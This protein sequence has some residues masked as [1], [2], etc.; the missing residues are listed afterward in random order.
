MTLPKNNNNIFH[1]P[2]T[3][4]TIPTYTFTQGRFQSKIVEQFWTLN[5]IDFFNNEY[6]DISVSKDYLQQMI[7]KYCHG[8]LYELTKSNFDKIIKK[9][10]DIEIFIIEDDKS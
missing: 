4:L 10:D 8:F 2:V 1:L 7:D 6:H 5:G 3:V 9:I